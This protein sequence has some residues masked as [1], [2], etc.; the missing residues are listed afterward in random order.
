MSHAEADMGP[1]RFDDADRSCRFMF[2]LWVIPRGARLV[3]RISFAGRGVRSV[4]A[5]RG[6]GKTPSP[7]IEEN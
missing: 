6:D 1:S 7:A 3:R 4:I 2:E 5:P